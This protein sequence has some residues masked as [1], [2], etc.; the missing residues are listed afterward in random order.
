M[1]LNYQRP[2]QVLSM[3]GSYL[4]NYAIDEST[5]TYRSAAAANPSKFIQ[6]HLGGLRTVHAP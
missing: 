5:K 3:L 1:L 2:V 6:T 4:P